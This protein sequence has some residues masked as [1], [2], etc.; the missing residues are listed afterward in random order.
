MLSNIVFEAHLHHRFIDVLQTLSHISYQ[1][2]DISPA[3]RIRAREIE[4]T[5]RKEVFEMAI[6]RTQIQFICLFLYV[7]ANQAFGELINLFDSYDRLMICVIKKVPPI[8]TLLQVFI[9][10]ASLLLVSLA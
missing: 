3:N 5:N 4:Q 9:F 8:S 10:K 6:L 2:V 7:E 1:Y